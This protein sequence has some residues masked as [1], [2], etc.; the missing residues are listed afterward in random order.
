MYAGLWR[1][2]PGPIWVRILIL[3]VLLI[4]ILAA[5][6]FWIFPWVDVMLTP[7][8]PVTVNQ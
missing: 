2:L 7:G 3:L 4:V 8:Q 6:F 5:L 1:L